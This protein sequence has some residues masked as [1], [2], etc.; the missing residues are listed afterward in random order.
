M[1]KYDQVIRETEEHQR[2][3]QALIKTICEKLLERGLHHDKTKLQSPEIDAFVEMQ[4]RTHDVAY[5]SEEYNKALEDLKP[6]LEHH[7]A[8]NRHHPEHYP[9][10]IKGM[11]L[12]DIV[13][14]LCD[15]KASTARYK[16]GNLLTSID[17]N[18]KRFNISEDLAAILRN[19]A[20]MLEM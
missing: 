18:V 3:V 10:G 8:K 17:I 9:D 16:A 14:M 13:E 19:T 7:Y 12:V 20:E 2:V 5:G 1:S 4:R 6:A 15:W 11:N